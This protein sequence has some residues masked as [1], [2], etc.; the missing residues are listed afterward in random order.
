MKLTKEEQMKVVTDSFIW[1][2]EQ[3]QIACASVD[4]L[5]ANPDEASQDEIE[6]ESARMDE[7]TKRLRYELNILKKM[8]P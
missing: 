8:T 5:I 7:L 2:K 6:A 1:W 4:L 3:A